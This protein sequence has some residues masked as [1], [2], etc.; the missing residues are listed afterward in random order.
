MGMFDYINGPQMKCVECDAELRGWQSKDGPCELD[1]LDF[2]QVDRFYT[3]CD[4]CGTWHEWNRK[5]ARG[6]QDFSLNTSLKGR[7]Y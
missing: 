3:S 4:K 5:P 1:T 6:L 2:T 7:Y